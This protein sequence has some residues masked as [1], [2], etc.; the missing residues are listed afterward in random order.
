MKSNKIIY[1]LTGLALISTASCAKKPLTLSEQ[2][3]REVVIGREG[4]PPAGVVR[5]CWEEPMVVSQV[6]NPGI[7]PDGEYYLPA[8]VVTREVRM[9]K[10]R[11]CRAD[12]A[13]LE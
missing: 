7:D 13:A 12:T 2:M 3:A 9:G 10:W 5:Y 1:L 8:A 6:Q 11:P 4:E